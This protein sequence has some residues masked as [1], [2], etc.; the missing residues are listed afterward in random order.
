MT[1]EAWFYFPMLKRS[2]VLDDPSSRVAICGFTPTDL[3]GEWSPER[4]T[5]IRCHKCTVK[6]M[7]RGM[8]GIKAKYAKEKL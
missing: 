1:A 6:L 7:Q 5:E 2:H 4:A 3:S 8:R